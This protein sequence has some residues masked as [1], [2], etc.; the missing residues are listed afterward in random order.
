MN[1]ASYKITRHYTS[2]NPGAEMLREK[3]LQVQNLYALAADREDGVLLNDVPF[4]KSPRIF[5]RKFIDTF[6]HKITVETVCSDDWMECGDYL[7]YDG[8]VWL[9]LN[10][11]V[12][13]Q[14]YCRATFMSCDWQVFWVND[15]GE[16]KSQYVV[17]QNST[18]YNS[19]ETSTPVMTLGTAQHMLRMQCNPD[20]VLLDSPIRF[21]IDKNLKKPTC[22][23]ITQN[24]N[25]SYN[26]GKGLC[27]ITVMEAAFNA[28]TDKLITLPDKRSV[29]ICDY[30]K[31]TDPSETFPT[32]DIKATIS[33]NRELKVG[34]Y[35]TYK[36]AFSDLEG[37]EIPWEDVSFRW[38][39]QST[40]DPSFL[41]QEVSGN[42]I[43]ISAR[44]E[45]LI[46][47][48]FLLLVY[49]GNNV[50]SRA[51]ISLAGRW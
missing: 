2:S 43:K 44:D 31:Q 38:D 51:E 42:A 32:A 30:V 5:D 36:V 22:Y 34:F 15:D 48:S 12:F 19:G 49:V 25:S 33:G 39:V 29:W 26:Y 6:H 27:C 16:I 35:R 46:G 9:C 14:L 37:K 21:A 50:M 47:S 20:T 4:H 28:D 24:D 3:K 41:K 1:L 13:H 45:C 8:M 18:Q 23:K 11:Y 10:S 17:D 7:E 40:F